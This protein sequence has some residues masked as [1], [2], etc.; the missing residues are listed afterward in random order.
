MAAVEYRRE[1]LVA[2]LFTAATNSVLGKLQKLLHHGFSLTTYG[3]LIYLT[4]RSAITAYHDGE[5]VLGARTILIW[6]ARFILP[7]GLSVAFLV[8]LGTA[9][10][11]LFN[12]LQCKASKT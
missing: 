9:L 2:D 1:Y 10:Q 7:V 6:P 3:I 11:P 12:P 8:T 4:G 5:I